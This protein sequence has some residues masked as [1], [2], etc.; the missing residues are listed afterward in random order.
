MALELQ[1]REWLYF[2]AGFVFGNWDWVWSG[3]LLYELLA[4][5]YYGNRLIEDFALFFAG[6]WLAT[7]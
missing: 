6:K 5:A 7:Q 3:F 4:Y 1:R 2:G